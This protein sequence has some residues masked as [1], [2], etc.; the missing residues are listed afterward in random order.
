M[1]GI[2]TTDTLLELWLFHLFNFVL[3]LWQNGAFTKLRPKLPGSLFRSSGS[4][5][6]PG[7]DPAVSVCRPAR[8][9]TPAR[10]ACLATGVG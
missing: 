5:F 2:N 8:P 4:I 6:I 1:E 9:R 7:R 10:P 3:F